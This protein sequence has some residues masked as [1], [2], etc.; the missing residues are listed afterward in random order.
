MNEIIGAT[1]HLWNVMLN[2]AKNSDEE[3]SSEETKSPRVN[4]RLVRQAT[5]LLE[6]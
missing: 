6:S 3:D 2:M 4:K 1:L 5:I